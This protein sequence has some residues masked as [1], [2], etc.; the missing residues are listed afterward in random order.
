MRKNPFLFSEEEYKFLHHVFLKQPENTK[1]YKRIKS[2]KGV[3][4]DKSEVQL[5]KRRYSKW[6]S[7]QNA[8][9]ILFV[10]EYSDY[11]SSSY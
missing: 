5:V 7:T 3:G 1:L 11:D 9:G 6:K 10:N 4:L 2:K 8:N